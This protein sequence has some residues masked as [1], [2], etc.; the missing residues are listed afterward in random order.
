[1]TRLL[2]SAAL[3]LAL[4]VYSVALI[5]YGK[6]RYEHQVPRYDCDQGT[7]EEVDCGV[8]SGP[9]GTKCWRPKCR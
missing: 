6:R 5:N 7:I 8:A 3:M 9:P 2:V 4:I 1:M